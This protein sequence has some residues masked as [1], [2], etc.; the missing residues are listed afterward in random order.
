MSR[1]QLQSFLEET[2]GSA[3]DLTPEE[4]ARYV[5]GTMDSNERLEF[6]AFLTSSPEA[7]QD[8]ADFQ[9][10]L[11]LEKS[12]S[13]AR[14]SAPQP[15]PTSIPLRPPVIS[16]KWLLAA[17]ALAALASAAT[18]VLT[19][20]SPTPAPPEKGEDL[21]N[22]LED[23]RQKLDAANERVVELDAQVKAQVQLNEKATKENA[24][25]NEELA[26]ANTE[27]E[28]P[29][30]SAGQK[31]ASRP[32]EVVTKPTPLRSEPALPE[33]QGTVYKL[34]P[35][36]AVPDSVKGVGGSED[37]LTIVALSGWNTRVR[38]KGVVLSWA[39]DAPRWKLTLQTIGGIALHDEPSIQGQGFTLPVTINLKPGKAYTWT[40]SDANN[41]KRSR[42]FAFMT[43]SKKEESELNQALKKART[44]DERVDLLLRFGLYDEGSALVDKSETIQP[45][46]KDYLRGQI[47]GLR[48]LV[49]KLVKDK[50][51]SR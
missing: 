43:I 45:A 26:K 12:E 24:R 29:K 38:P 28:Q 14:Q 21:R 23:I 22:E 39:G 10:Q 4:M 8:L 15:P 51:P 6:E 40:I 9:L 35:E 20:P 17:V 11:E 25:L 18:Y 41:N 49:S 1:E 36:L 47:A 19:R 30:T 33:I 7:R 3:V 44:D 16:F 5:D 27:Q 31:E 42:S 46:V 2:E 34:H 32:P 37:D 50:K 48:G 13:L